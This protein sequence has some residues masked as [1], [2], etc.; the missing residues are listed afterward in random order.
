MITLWADSRTV[1]CIKRLACYG[2]L[3]RL[4]YRGWSAHRVITIDRFHCITTNIGHS[5]MVILQWTH[6]FISSLQQKFHSVISLTHAALWYSHTL[7][8]QSVHHLGGHW[9]PHVQDLIMAIITHSYWV[10]EWRDWVKII[11]GL[12]TYKPPIQKFLSEDFCDSYI[13][14]RFIRYGYSIYM[15][16]KLGLCTFSI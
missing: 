5:C 3:T 13:V 16:I 8:L 15:Y 7:H 10:P 9:C 1:T 11:N 12:W 2:D 6:P 4:Y 14:S